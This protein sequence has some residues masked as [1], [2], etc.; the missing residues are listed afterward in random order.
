MK[1]TDGD[2]LYGLLHAKFNK[3]RI[4]PLHKR[5]IMVYEMPKNK[6]LWISEPPRKFRYFC[7]SIAPINNYSDPLINS[8]LFVFSMISLKRRLYK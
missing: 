3:K 1:R 4:I 6:R 8:T 2:L 7:G 5:S